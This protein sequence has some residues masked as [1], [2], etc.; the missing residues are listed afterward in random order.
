MKKLVIDVSLA[1]TD[2]LLRPVAEAM[3]SLEHLPEFPLQV[4]RDLVSDSLLDL[5]IGFDTAALTAGDLRAVVQIGRRFELV[6]S[7]LTAFQGYV[8]QFS[9]RETSQVEIG[10]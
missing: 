7:A 4:F 6:A 5:A 8:H 10:R 9:L 1:A 3:G 2:Q